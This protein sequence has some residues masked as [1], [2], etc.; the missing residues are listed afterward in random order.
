MKPVVY[1]LA[2][3]ALALCLAAAPAAAQRERPSGASGGGSAVGNGGS[4]SGGG[5]GAMSSGGS[6]GGGSSVS[7]GGGSSSGGGSVYSGGS[8][9]SGG[10]TAV[11]RGGG[12]GERA[13]AGG[14]TGY[15]R[16][17]YG[18]DQDRAVPRG[19]RPN[20]GAPVTGQAVVRPRGTGTVEWPWNNEWNRWYDYYNPWYYGSWYWGFSPWGY[21]WDPFWWGYYGGPPYGGYYGGYGYYGGAAGAGGE[22]YAYGHG[23]LKL[24][25]D[26]KDAEVYVDGYYMGIVD[27]FDGVFQGMQLEAGAHK[28]EIRAPGFQTISFDV[29]IEPNDTISYRGQLQEIKK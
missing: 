22:S 5:G 9:S 19:A 16:P 15:A 25:V 26:P 8:S 24:K 3:A 27:D 18:S 21:Y 20:P 23:T 6:S 13:G 28:I 7:G 12:G 4:H 11:R 29:R 2:G 10:G 17:G 1:T 14:R